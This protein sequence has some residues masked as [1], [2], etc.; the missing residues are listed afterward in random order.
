MPKEM[1]Y[2]EVRCTYAKG[3]NANV[4]EGAVYTVEE[5]EPNEEGFYSINGEWVWCGRF[6]DVSND[7]PEQLELPLDKPFDPKAL[8]REFNEAFGMSGKPK[9]FWYGL[10]QEEL[11]EVKDAAAHLL[12]EMADLAYVSVAFVGA[13]GTYEESD[14]EEVHYFLESVDDNVL[15]E[16]F[17]RV[18]ES[19]M[20]KL[21]P[22]GKP[23]YRE[24]DGKVL[25]GPNYVPPDLSDLV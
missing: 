18:H 7:V 24:S 6:E 14:A 2:K 13:G 3:C 17:R 22:D 21:G 11:A 15:E 20:S 4:T 8:V 16:A 1:K 19:N 25:K 10:V 23:M 5:D 12:K 9:E